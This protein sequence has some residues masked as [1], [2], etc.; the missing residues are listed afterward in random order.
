MNA[1][2]EATQKSR[3]LLVDDHMIVRE[4][5]KKVIL[6]LQDFE[7]AGTASDGFEAIR[8]V[9]SLRPDIVI[10]DVGMPNL[11]GVQAT[12]EIKK[13]NKRIK[14]IIFT[15]YADMTHAV[16]LYKEGIS[17]YVL[18]SDPVS[19]LAMA[20]KAV[21]D[22]G[23]Y[24]SAVIS[25]I[26]RERI[27]QLEVKGAGKAG[28]VQDGIPLLSAREKEIFPLLA[29]GKSIKEIAD[30]LCISPKTVETHKYN[31]MEKLRVNSIADLTKIALKRKLIEL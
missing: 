28:E 17:G 1:H 26:I 18:K 25:D 14:V 2:E 5:I 11:D 16:S 7:V 12:H 3:V 15:M 22:G 27:E 24:F 19:D 4:G 13:L 8:K 10:M 29:D 9:K 6:S 31:I 30:T 21:R 20:L 23:T